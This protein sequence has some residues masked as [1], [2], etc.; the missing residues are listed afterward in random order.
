MHA[1]VN[2]IAGIATPVSFRNAG[3]NSAKETWRPAFVL[4]AASDGAPAAIV[5]PGGVFRPDRVIDL[6]GADWK[7]LKLKSI[8]ER[9]DD[10]ERVALS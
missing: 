5:L 9:G 4:S 8:I 2:L 6:E 10:F 1:G 3:L 7:Q